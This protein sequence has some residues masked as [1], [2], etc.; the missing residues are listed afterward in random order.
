MHDV[1]HACVAANRGRP[2]QSLFC[3]QRI[4]NRTLTLA[5]E[6]RGHAAEEFTHVDDLPADELDALRAT[7]VP[8]LEP[9]T[10]LEAIDVATAAFLSE[11]RRGDRELAD[12]LVEPLTNVVRASL[13]HRRGGGG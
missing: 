4:R 6:R 9:E 12:R 5:S 10:L 7:L 1:L 13:D 3:L 8:D 11:L 2:W